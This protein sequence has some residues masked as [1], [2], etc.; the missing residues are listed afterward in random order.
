MKRLILQLTLLLRTGVDNFPSTALAA[1]CRGATLNISGT[2]AWGAGD[3]RGAGEERSK[4]EEKRKGPG[5]GVCQTS[6]TGSDPTRRD[7]TGDRSRETG[8]SNLPIPNW[9]LCRFFRDLNDS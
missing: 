6:K 5:A 3:D 9:G 7:P 8:L 4:L 2:H 1:V